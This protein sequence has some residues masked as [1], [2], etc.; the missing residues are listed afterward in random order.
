MIPIPDSIEDVTADWLTAVLQSGGIIVCRVE[1]VESTHIGEGVGMLSSMLQCRVHY[2]EPTGG[3]PLSLVVKLLP[4]DPLARQSLRVSHGFEREI[5]F[6]REVA[7]GAPI[8]VPAF[9][10]GDY[11]RHQ[12]VVVLEDLGHLE[13]RNQIHGLHDFET[14]AAARQ[15]ARLH[16]RYWNESQA[17]GYGWMPVHDDQ[18]TL[19]YAR[20]WELFEEVY[21]LRIGKNAVALG[22]R[23]S[24]ALE[25]LRAEFAARPRTI[26][27]GDF[28]ADNLFF[29]DGGRSDGVVVIDWQLCTRSLGSLDVARLLGG[30][31]PSNER[32]SYHLESFTA[33]HETLINEGVSDYSLEDALRDFRL[34]ALMNLCLPVHVISK[35]GP[36]PGGRRG[37][38][39]DAI[40]IRMF[41]FAL[42]VDAAALLPG[43]TPNI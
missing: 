8:R 37:Q 4:K 22:R 29:G 10:Y 42:E 24:T 1:T 20:Y 18:S 35:W 3:E 6:Y 41:A 25:W 5:R 23:L 15:I 27:H 21:G 36:D 9:F 28:R 31:E 16:A 43:P 7:A 32:T 17:D 39:L 40:A 26:C 30:S 12:A 33:W 34:G 13:A 19:A 14:V 11:D 38:L 2:D